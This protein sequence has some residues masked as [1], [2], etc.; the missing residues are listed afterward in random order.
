MKLLNKQEAIKHLRAGT[1][2]LH[3]YSGKP[4]SAMLR[5]KPEFHGCCDYGVYL[6]SANAIIDWGW[7]REIGKANPCTTVY[8]WNL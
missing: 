7:L 5:H 8:E 1:H 3:L 2:E 6:R 4:C